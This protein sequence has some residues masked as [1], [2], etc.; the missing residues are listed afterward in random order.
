MT[1][2]VSDE[3][4]SQKLVPAVMRAAQILDQIAKSTQE[5]GKGSADGLKLSDLARRTGLP[6]SSV[7]GLCQTLVHLKLLKLNSDGSFT[8]GS[9]SVRWANVFHGWQ[10][11]CRC[12]S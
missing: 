2:T 10:R 7:H 8:M 6:K 4:S 5:G 11:H 1:K 9:Q 3:E 12:I